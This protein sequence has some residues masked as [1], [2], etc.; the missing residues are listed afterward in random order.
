MM[1]DL[2]AGRIVRWGPVH[3]L[4]WPRDRLSGTPEAL[5]ERERG[6]LAGVH[7]SR[8][9]EWSAGRS[10]ARRLASHA[11]DLAPRTIDVL[12]TR[13]GAPAIWAAGQ[14][15]DAAVSL[16][17]AGEWVVGA[18]CVTG[19]V[20]VDVCSLDQAV[21]VRRTTHLVFS[22]RERK[23]LGGLV[24][25]TDAASA[26]ALAEAGGKAAGGRDGHAVFWGLSARPEIHDLHTAAISHGSAALWSLPGAVVAAVHAPPRD[27][28]TRSLI[29]S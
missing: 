8:R 9:A 19:T 7:R 13:S 14:P 16:S 2:P 26:W 1:R 6:Q 11:L 17:H 22:D 4:A 21:R 18:V 23:R 12:A 5:S 10:L 28:P 29:D 25:P 20:G 24:R 3:V 15:A 27:H